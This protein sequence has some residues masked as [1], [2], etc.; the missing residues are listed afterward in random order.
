MSDRPVSARPARSYPAA[1]VILSGR[2]PVLRRLVAETGPP[3]V[4]PP[5][6]T[7]F[8]ALVRSILYQQLAG[9]AAAALHGGLIAALGDDITPQQLPSLSAETLR[10]AGLSA[11]KAASLQD[12]AAKVLDG[13][14]V[15]DPPRLRAESDAEIVARL[16]AVRGIRQWAAEVL[17]LFGSGSGGQGAGREGRAR[18]ASAAGRERRRD[19]RP[20]LRSPGHREVDG[21]DVP[22]VPAAAPGRVANRRSRGQERIRA[23]VGD[24][25]ADG[26]RPRA[27]RRAV[28]AL[29]IGGRLVLLAGRRALRR[30]S[31]QCPHPLNR[32]GHQEGLPA[33]WHMASSA[34]A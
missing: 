27:A 28:P 5:T 6:E 12:L 23:G 7:H 1:A 26:E 29:P 34:I 8:A 25:D 17:P 32:D 21:G 30:R 20:A 33:A 19:C 14:V 4:G 11:N 3:R 2:D 13:T 16:C 22:H 9:A 18:P 15:L 31:R 10:S 24:P